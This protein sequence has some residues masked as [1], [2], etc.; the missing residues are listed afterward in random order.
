M[1]HPPLDHAV[2]GRGLKLIGHEGGRTELYDLAEDP[3]EAEDVAPTRPTEAGA[4]RAVLD[5]HVAGSEIQAPALDPATRD[6][7]RA[8]GYIE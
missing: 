8:L 2:R 3:G 7:L 4:L 5:A 1:E 6:V